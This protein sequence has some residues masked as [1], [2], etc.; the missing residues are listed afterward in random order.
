MI[1]S[2]IREGGSARTKVAE[3]VER[4]MLLSPVVL[5]EL[6]LSNRI[7][8]RSPGWSEC[9]ERGLPGFGDLCREAGLFVTEGVH[10]GLAVQI[11]DHGCGVP[12]QDHLAVWRGIAEAVHAAG[13]KVVMSLV[14]PGRATSL[15]GPSDGQDLVAP[16]AVA[17]VAPVIGEAAVLHQPRDLSLEEIARLTGAYRQ[18]ATDAVS[19]GMDGVE[20]EASGCNLPMQFLSTNSNLRQDAYG[21]SS[22][23]RCRFVREVMRAMGEAIGPGR[24]GI[25]IDPAGRDH[26]IADAVPSAT[27]AA[28]LRGLSDSGF[29]Y[30]HLRHS[31]MRALD[32]LMLTR[33]YWSGPI[34]VSG[35]FDR[36]TAE[37]LVASRRVDAVVLDL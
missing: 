12:I 33:G 34:I 35:A 29:A 31:P 25:R 18:A 6:R 2:E 13:S 7:V 32:T 3:T 30:V 36:A 20:L 21:G 11:R 37:A 8:V 10:P 22:W 4:G 5:G 16:S 26:G 17:C 27:Y 14:H 19:A 9:S 15:E 24:V 28:L 1:E 23:K